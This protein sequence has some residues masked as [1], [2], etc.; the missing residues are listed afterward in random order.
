MVRWLGLI[1]AL[2]AF[3][4]GCSGS[5]SGSGSAVP[6]A[7]ARAVVP[8][9]P[10][11]APSSLAAPPR[12]DFLGTAPASPSSAL[13]RTQGVHAAF[14]NGETPLTNGVYYLQLPNGNIFG[15]YSYLTDT[16]YIYHFDMGYEYVVDANDGKGGAYMYDFASTHWWYTSPLYPFPYVYDFSLSSVL[17]YYP[18]T[19][20]AGHYTTK[21]RYFQ[22]FSNQATITLPSA[23]ITPPAL[24]FT[25]AGGAAAQTFSV[26]ET[27]YA[28]AFTVDA[29]ACA[30][31]AT[32]SP[33]SATTY[34]VVPQAAG[35]CNAIVGDTN[36]GRAAVSIA[37]NVPTQ[38][39]Y[40][41]NASPS[42]GGF[43]RYTLPLT[44]SSTPD[45]AIGTK[46]TVAVGVDASGDVAAIDI[47]AQ[48]TFYSA[49][50]LASSLPAATFGTAFSNS[51]TQQIAFTNAG[52]MYVNLAANTILH[53]APPF[54][55][56]AAPS[57]SVNN[58]AFKTVGGV[59]FDAA[60][61]LY[62]TNVTTAG[63][64]LFAYA[65]PYSGTP[66]ATSFV[67]GTRYHAVAI[68]GAKLFVVS[69]QNGANRV[70]VYPLPLHANSTPAFSITDSL[71]APEAIAFDT[72]GN[73]YVGNFLSSS[74]TMY[75]PP[76]SAFS[77]AVTTIPAPSGFYVYNMAIGK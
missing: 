27:G 62:V 52:D 3:L 31:I 41:G 5:G 71:S 14:F 10:P 42:G 46:R 43:V 49:P 57:A 19:A 67:A 18:D 45:F 22:N 1:V 56:G 7:V 37:V 6:R 17:Y 9:S 66:I 48:L 20:N 75:Q 38:H 50:L 70:D 33:L 64:N 77:T 60:Q 51:G 23:Q 32:I 65:P 30:G 11:P 4:A 36:A 24:T 12:P 28:G 59:A 16:H 61:N 58:V 40:M 74:I 8:T 26:S 53:F 34:S 54:T 55:N 2:G 29:S 76:F 13:R 35:T 68:N 73:L 39:L 15:Y 72:A 44:A 47:N 69:D 25:A 21:P 63:S